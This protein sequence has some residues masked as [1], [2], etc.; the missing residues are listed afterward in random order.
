MKSCECGCLITKA[1]ISKEK[2]DGCYLKARKDRKENS[3]FFHKLK[4]ERANR[5]ALDKKR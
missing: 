2:C 1:S 4:H 5:M 3:E